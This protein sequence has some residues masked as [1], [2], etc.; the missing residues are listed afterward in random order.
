MCGLNLCYRRRCAV[1]LRCRVLNT[2]VARYDCPVPACLCGRAVCRKPDG[3]VSIQSGTFGPD[4]ID[5]FEMGGRPATNAEWKKHVD[6]TGGKAPLRRNKGQIPLEWR[7]TPIVNRTPNR[8]MTT[9]R[10]YISRR[11]SARGRMHVEVLRRWRKSAC[12]HRPQQCGCWLVGFNRS[13]HCYKPF[14]RNGV[15]V[16]EAVCPYSMCCWFWL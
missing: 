14:V 2:T 15:Y 7:I 16:P 13:H 5:A 4:C 9:V 6:A 8:S 11:E 12:Q 3:F 1:T 10:R